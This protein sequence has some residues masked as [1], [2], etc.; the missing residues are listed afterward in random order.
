MRG[1]K[2]WGCLALVVFA[3]T[4]GLTLHHCV[5]RST[6]AGHVASPRAPAP[7]S[8]LPGSDSGAGS[9]KC[10]PPTG[11]VSTRL[12]VIGDDGATVK[13]AE[14]LGRRIADSPLLVPSRT[15]AT[16]DL[17]VTV[18][19]HVSWEDYDGRTMISYR[20]NARR[21][22]SQLFGSYTG[23]CWLDEVE[24]C[25]TQAVADAVALVR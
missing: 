6:P 2:H 12:E 16:C 17:I 15:S 22:G 5:S 14:A 21:H 7:P 10:S 24:R 4:A 13:F 9:A 23:S 25:A 18:A 20:V 8:A 3:V 19:N 11:R 1:L